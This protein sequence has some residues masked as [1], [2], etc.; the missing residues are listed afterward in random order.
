M[1]P[2]KKVWTAPK[3]KRPIKMG[4]VPSWNESQLISL[5]I[6]KPNATKALRKD[7]RKPPIVINLSG[8]LE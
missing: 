1:T 6:K 5:A 4:A 7:R 3:K 2:I 8:T